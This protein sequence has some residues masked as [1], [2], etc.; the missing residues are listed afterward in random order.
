[1]IPLPYVLLAFLLSVGAS[2]ALGYWKGGQHKADSIAA[3][4]ARE[5]ALVAKVQLETAA[6]IAKIEVRNTT[7]R[8]KAEVQIRENVI[9]RCPVDADGVRLINEA[10]AP[11]GPADDGKLPRPDATGG[12][13]PRGRHPQAD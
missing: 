9:Y 13:D 2:G 8:Q 3:Q 4:A 11:P 7:I 10:L 1:M 12:P 5:A 6:A